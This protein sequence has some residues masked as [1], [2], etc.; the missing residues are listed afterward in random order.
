MELA[1]SILV[2]EAATDVPNPGA[3]IAEMMA[4]LL[5]RIEGLLSIYGDRILP[6]TLAV[7]RLVLETEALRAETD[8]LASGLA[9]DTVVGTT[10]A[11]LEV[12]AAVLIKAPMTELLVEAKDESPKGLI[13]EL[14]AATKEVV[15]LGLTRGLVI[16]PGRLLLKTLM[17]VELSEEPSEELLKVAWAV[18]LG[19][20]DKM[21]G[22]LVKRGLDVVAKSVLL[23]ADSPYSLENCEADREVLGETKRWKL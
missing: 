12:F 22:K 9:I 19:L 18:T 11:L 23:G 5:G 10:M 21:T 20:L 2:V 16:E 3:T 15:A 13:V 17:I 8:V 14:L 1:G 7:S 4:E 6:R